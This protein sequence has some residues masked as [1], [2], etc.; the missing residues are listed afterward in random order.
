MEALAA[1]RY[2]V[3]LR[4]SRTIRVCVKLASISKRYGV[5]VIESTTI[6][7]HCTARFSAISVS[8]AIAY[9]QVLGRR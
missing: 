8:A 1:V 4:T 3:L 2:T 9:S 6:L 5:L 7:C